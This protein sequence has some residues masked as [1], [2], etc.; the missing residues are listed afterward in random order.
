MNTSRNKQQLAPLKA[1][2]VLEIDSVLIGNTT[3]KF[4]TSLPALTDAAPPKITS[5][6]L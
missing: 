3:A 4:P 6:L 2:K 5:P 1:V